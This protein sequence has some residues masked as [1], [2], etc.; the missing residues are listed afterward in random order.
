MKS[1]SN[2]TLICTHNGIFRL[3]KIIIKIVNYGSTTRA[4]TLRSNLPN[5]FLKKKEKDLSVGAHPP[6][7][8]PS[9]IFHL[10]YIR[11]LLSDL[12]PKVDL[13]S[14]VGL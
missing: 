7:G 1:I 4:W 8:L 11:F 2:A 3:K 9:Q 14:E 10:K 5:S 13:N 6:P 12:K